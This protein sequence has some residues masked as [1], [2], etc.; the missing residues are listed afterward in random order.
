MVVL[1]AP[2][3]SDSK[4]KGI[5]TDVCPLNRATSTNQTRVQKTATLLVYLYTTLCNNLLS[6]NFMVA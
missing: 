2:N 1:N 6:V 3:L 5:S 4:T